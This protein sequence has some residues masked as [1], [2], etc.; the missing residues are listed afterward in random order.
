MGN[1]YSLTAVNQ[2]ADSLTATNYNI[3]TFTIVPEITH[4]NP[5]FTSISTHPQ[6]VLIEC[7]EPMHMCCRLL[8]AKHTLS[9][10]VKLS[11][12]N[13]MIMQFPIS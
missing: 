4:R 12:E 3:Q 10:A 9:A 11:K 7:K 8:T 6:N 1:S 13:L 5:T 2:L